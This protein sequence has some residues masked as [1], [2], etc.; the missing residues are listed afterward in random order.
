M[1]MDIPVLMSTNARTRGF[2]T[3]ISDT[4]SVKIPQVRTVHKFAKNLFQQ[5]Y[6][7]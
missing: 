3:K 7:T 1:V 2:V 4:E 6:Y 5:R